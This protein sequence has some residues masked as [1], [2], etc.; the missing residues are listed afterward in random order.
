MVGAVVSTMPV[1]N[2]S[3]RQVVDIIGVINGIAFQTNIL[4]LNA[5]VG[6]ARAGEQD[7]GFAVVASEVRSLTQRSAQAAKEINVLTDSS[8][9]KITDGSVL[10]EKAGQTMLEI[11]G[12]VKNVSTIVSEIAG[13]SAE[14]KT[15]IEEINRAISSMDQATQQNA[16]LVKEAAAAAQARQDQATNRAVIVGGFKMEE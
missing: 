6:A 2:Q 12:S 3:S 16:V 10:V 7:R 1:I 4:A 5:A 14:Q 11:I 15:G 9:S 8:V 13:A